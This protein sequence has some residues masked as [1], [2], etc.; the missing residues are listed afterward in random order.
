MDGNS[1]EVHGVDTGVA[2]SLLCSKIWSALGSE[3]IF[4]LSPWGGKQVF[5]VFGSLRTELGVRLAIDFRLTALILESKLTL[6][7]ITVF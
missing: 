3:K 6:I 1:A 5:S 7:V 4:Q 2:V